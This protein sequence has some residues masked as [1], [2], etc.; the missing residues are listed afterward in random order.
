M[1]VYYFYGPYP[2][3]FKTWKNGDKT[4][5]LIDP[6]SGTVA[7]W[8]GERF[9]IRDQRGNWVTLG[10]NHYAPNYSFFFVELQSSNKAWRSDDYLN[11]VLA[12]QMPLDVQK[13]VVM[14]AAEKYREVQSLTRRQQSQWAKAIKARANDCCYVTGSILALEA[15]H[16]KPFCICSNED[17]ISLDN[18]VCLT[19]TVHSLFDSIST[20]ADIPK[21]DP[22]YKLIDLKKLEELIARRDKMN[23]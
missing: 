21:D 15:A 9:R 11:Q 17:A 3:G 19:A 1:A 12:K 6:D 16:I 8:F 13:Y 18:G 4:Q 7:M 20:V 5:P 23:G 22:L 10:E 2:E 14:P